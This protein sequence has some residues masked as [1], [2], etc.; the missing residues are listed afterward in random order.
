MKRIKYIIFLLAVLLTSSCSESFL[1]QTPTTATSKDDFYKTQEDLYQALIAAYDPLQWDDYF[2]QYLPTL[3]AS[4]IRGDDMLVGGS[5]ESDQGYLYLMHMFSCT[6]VNS[7]YMFWTIYYSGVNRSNLVINNI[8]NVEN[9][10][11]NTRS[12]MRAEAYFLR[13]YY[14]HWLWKNYGNVPYYDKNLELPY[15]TKQEKAD[16][17]YEKIVADLDKALEGSALPNDVPASEKGRITRAA[18]QMLKARVV[19]YQNDESRYPEVL[20]DMEEIISGG[21]YALMDDYESIFLDANEWCKESIWEINYVDNGNR[22]W[23][24]AI[25]SGGTVL[26]ALIGINGLSSNPEFQSG[27]GFGPVPKETYDLYPATDQRK[28]GGI[29]AF[30]KLKEKYPDVSYSPRFQDTG[31]FLKKYLPRVGYND[32][33]GDTPLNFKNNLRIFRYSETLLNAAELILRGAGGTTAEAQDYYD[34]VRKRALGDNF[35]QKTITLDNVLQERRLEFVGEG[36][37]F[38]D[39]VRSGKA[40]SVLGSR[41]YTAEKKYLPIPSSEIDQTSGEY[42][43]VQ[44]PGY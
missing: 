16:D 28:D 15:M 20:K 39:L 35:V 3:F 33:P 5:S 25:A 2:N 8:D 21:Q 9:M 1:E 26:P 24:S 34:Q 31:Y 14:Y 10:D 18:A 12:R 29:L 19:M 6:S 4:D 17:V 38:W 32:N 22:G 30:S 40:E 36:V 13:A 41:G 27:W 11:E 23:G 37:R 44:N 42:Q 43:L 7:P